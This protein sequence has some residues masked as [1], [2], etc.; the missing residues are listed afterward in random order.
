MGDVVWKRTIRAF[1][2]TP[3]LVD[4]ETYLTGIPHYSLTLRKDILKV[5]RTQSSISVNPFLRHSLTTCIRPEYRNEESWF[6]I[7]ISYE[8]CI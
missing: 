4:Y 8:V 3:A 5:A 6:S 1:C 2:N 7:S